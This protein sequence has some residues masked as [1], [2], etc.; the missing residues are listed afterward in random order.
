M[1]ASDLIQ[2]GFDDGI[3]SITLNR[4]DKLNA[5]CEPMHLCLLD[6]LREASA[7]DDVR[8]VLLTGEGRGF[9]AGQDLAERVTAPKAEKVDLGETLENFYNPIIR[10]IRDMPKAVICAVNG[11]AAGAG[12]NIALAC[13]IVLAAQSAK[14]IQPF[15]NIGLLPDS[16]G[17]WLLPAL[18]GQARAKALA[19]LATPVTAEEAVAWGLIWQAV[20]DD[21][22]MP[23]ALELAAKLAQGSRQS[24][25]LI[26]RAIHAS[27]AQGLD[28]HL[29]LERDLQRE[30]GHGADYAEGVAAFL[31]KRKP[32]FSGAQD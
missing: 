32:N 19:M 7:R 20:E 17:T 25:A 9:C 15:C 3:F 21:A 13:D 2:S 6:M 11:I 16:G 14:F 29:D 18:I 4:P 27:A 5:F 31:E 8:V 28:A 24:Q 30:A 22:L 26:K 23:T 1:V 12:A 10:E